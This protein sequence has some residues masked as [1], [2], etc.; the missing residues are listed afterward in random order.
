MEK[1]TKTSKGNAIFVIIAIVIIISF[2]G[3]FNSCSSSTKSQKKY[4]CQ[5]CH[6]S[7]TNKDDVNSIIWRNMCE[8]CYNNYKFTQD[9]KEELKKYEENK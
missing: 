5:V 9:L 7:F 6:K 2:F 8:K 4:T 1:Q 3:G